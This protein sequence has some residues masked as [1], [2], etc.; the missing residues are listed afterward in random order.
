MFVKKLLKVGLV[1]M[2]AL[3]VLYADTVRITSK[4]ANVRSG[5]STQNKIL[6][7]AHK[8]DGYDLIRTTGQRVK[9]SFKGD[10]GW[11]YK[12]LVDIEDDIVEEVTSGGCN[13]A[14][15]TSVAM[16]IGGTALCCAYTGFGCVACIV[17][18]GVATYLADDTIEGALC[19]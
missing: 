2:F 15:A 1:G 4:Y 3:N 13:S 14:M 12:D 5:S 7:K 11:I 16:D 8:G 18:V 19:D 6:G 17:G 10:Y 9:V